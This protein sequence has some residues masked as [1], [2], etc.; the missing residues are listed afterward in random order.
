MNSCWYYPEPLFIGFE[1]ILGF[2][3]LTIGVDPLL[4]FG[5]FIPSL[6]AP[7]VEFFESGLALVPIY[8]DEPFAFKWRLFNSCG[9][10][11]FSLARPP[12]KLG[13]G[14]YEGMGFWY[15]DSNYRISAKILIELVPSFSW[16]VFDYVSFWEEL[17]EGLTSSS[18]FLMTCRW[19]LVVIFE[20][21]LLLFRIFIII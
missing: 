18:D 7:L 12:L 20:L 14:F 15:C 4:I 1:W 3:P 16:V 21:I 10:K 11:C 19:G 17:E 2:P 9:V 5:F 6:A 8:E 13:P